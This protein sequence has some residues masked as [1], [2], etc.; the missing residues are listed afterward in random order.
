M[1]CKILN[2][3]L[4]YFF[5]F[6]FSVVTKKQSEYA[7]YCHKMLSNVLHTFVCLSTNINFLIIIWNFILLILNRYS[8]YHIIL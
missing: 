5:V 8:N 3:S 7:K 2:V 6:Y 4:I 1:S